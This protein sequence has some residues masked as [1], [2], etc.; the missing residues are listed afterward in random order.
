MAGLAAI[1]LLWPGTFLDRSWTLNPGA[2]QQLAPLSSVAGP[3]FLLLSLI[4]LSSAVGWYR[5][6]R[7]G[8]ILAVVIIAIQV[9]SDIFN[10]LRGDRLRGALGVTIAGA[11]LV[12][13][14]SRGIR[15]TFSRSDG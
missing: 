11:L 9:V 12:Y 10:F 1:T 4:L 7:W 8:W 6:R 14:F 3:L 15:A 13:L 2:H 5:R